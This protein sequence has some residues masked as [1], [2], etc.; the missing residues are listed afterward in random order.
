MGWGIFA[1]VEVR[2]WTT[3]S[4]TGCFDLGGLQ[5]LDLAVIAS[6]LGRPADIIPKGRG[7][8][9]L[10]MICASDYFV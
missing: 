7:K 5:A 9:G 6:N 1:N 3:H 4:K 10:V 8:S 2:S